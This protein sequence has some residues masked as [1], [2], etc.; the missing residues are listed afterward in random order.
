MPRVSGSSLSCDL[1]TTLPEHGMAISLPTILAAL[2]AIPCLLAAGLLPAVFAD[3]SP[4]GT[5]EPQARAARHGAVQ[6]W[7]RSRGLGRHARHALVG[8][9]SHRGRRRFGSRHDPGRDIPSG[10]PAAL[11]GPSTSRRLSPLRLRPRAHDTL[12]RYA[13]RGRAG[14]ELLAGPTWCPRPPS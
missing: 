7:L 9:T 5:A 1:R 4:A 6:R 2:V 3:R 11:R 10:G 13:Q 8:R 12:G 14:A